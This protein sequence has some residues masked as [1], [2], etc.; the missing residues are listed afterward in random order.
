MEAMALKHVLFVHSAGV[1]QK[2]SGSNPL[3]HYLKRHTA[4]IEWHTP[5]FPRDE[6]QVYSNWMKVLK[7]TL[8]HIPDDEEL[9]LI[10]HSFGGSVVMK[11]LTENESPNQISKVVLISSPY[12]GC[13][14]KF[15]DAQN[16]LTGNA[17]NRI[18]SAIELYHIQSIDDDRVD[19]SHQACWHNKFPQL[20]V[21]KKTDGK[22]EFH[23]G[24]EELVTIIES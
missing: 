16:E 22:H 24:I 18:S 20:R 4:N 10:G 2:E 19:F 15:D 3:I 14:A 12:W 17:E 23:Q 9:L 1:Q 11:Y 7:D 8:A 5:S 21:I 6:G 13:D